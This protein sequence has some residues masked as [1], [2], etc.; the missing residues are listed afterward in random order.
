MTRRFPMVPAIS[1]IALFLASVSHVQAGAMTCRYKASNGDIYKGSFKYDEVSVV[2][3][4]TFNGEKIPAVRGCLNW[5]HVGGTFR[6]P[7]GLAW[8][9]F[10]V[11]PRFSGLGTDAKMFVIHWVG[12]RIVA[13]VVTE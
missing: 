7:H 12:D 11:Y 4:L 13:S 3:E 1:T 9:R 5:G 10:E 6:C 8:N 2:S